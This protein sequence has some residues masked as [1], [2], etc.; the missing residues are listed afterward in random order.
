MENIQIRN[1]WGWMDTLVK[2][3]KSAFLASIL[4]LLSTAIH[5]RETVTFYH[6]DILGSPVAATNA[7]GDVTWRKRYL[8]YGEVELNDQSGTLNKIGYTGH[9]EANEFGLVYMNARYYDPQIGRF[10]ATDPVGFSESNALSFN[11][12]AYANNNPYRFVDPDG[13]LP[14]ETVWDAA[15]VVYDLGKAAVGAAVGNQAMVAEGLGDAALDTA[16][17]FVPYAPAGSSKVTR[18]MAN[19]G[20]AKSGVQAN[21]AAG[22]AF[23][24]QVMG[25]LQQTQS[26]VVQQV[27]V[28]TQSGVKTRID[29]MGRDASGSIVCTECKASATASLTRNQAAAFPEIQQSGAVVVGKGKPGFPGGTQIPPSTVNIKRP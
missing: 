19:G 7:N 4:L 13:R 18:A 20:G 28:K 27:T 10:M 9:L 1:V 24:Q 15:N 2:S 26:G 21:K 11:R 3:V 22:D 25:Q 23:E 14:V 5:A 12:Y 17:M 16:A 8:P 29:L 6:T